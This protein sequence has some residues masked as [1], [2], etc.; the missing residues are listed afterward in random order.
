MPNLIEQ[1]LKN[2]TIIFG[3]D[4]TLFMTKQTHCRAYSIAFMQILKKRQPYLIESYK[5][6]VLKIHNA[7]YDSIKRTGDFNQTIVETIMFVRDL[8]NGFSEY[9]IDNRFLL[10]LSQDFYLA[11]R[12]QKNILYS[13]IIKDKNPIELEN[14]KC[15]FLLE[16]LQ[17]TKKKIGI[18]SN[19]AYDCVF[20]LLNR[21]DVSYM[22]ML[23]FMLCKGQLC[24]GKPDPEFATTVE[25]H[26]SAHTLYIGNDEID[27]SFASNT[28]MDYID[29]EQFTEEDVRSLTKEIIYT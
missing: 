9:M 25:K 22:R 4:D 27:R 8:E 12:F 13:E 6:E 21:A 10:F 1:I 17:N 7:F 11:L 23:D 2:D 19:S 14:G 20:F 15:I 16:V 24:I 26:I 29:I 28:K 5:E 3:F 18:I